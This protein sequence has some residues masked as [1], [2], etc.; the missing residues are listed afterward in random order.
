[1]SMSIEKVREITELTDTPHI[2][3]ER[4]EKVTFAVGYAFES[5]VNS[6]L[7]SDPDSAEEVASAVGC[8]FSLL[9]SNWLDSANPTT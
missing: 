3:K 1:M 7:E 8:A 2:N 5:L 4:F 9:V 6:W